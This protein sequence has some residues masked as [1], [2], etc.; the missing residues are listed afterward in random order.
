VISSAVA[1]PLRPGHPQTVYYLLGGG[2]SFLLALA[3]TLNQ[4]YYL[5]VVGL[6]PFQ[7]VLDGT[8]LEATCFL[9]EIP[10]GI[11]PDLYSRRL[12]VIVGVALLGAGML[13]QGLARRWPRR[14]WP[15]WCGAPARPSSLVPTR[16]GWPSRSART[17]SVRCS[18]ERP[19]SAWR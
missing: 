8:V 17:P 1:A 6:S 14:W 4:V 12:S 15:R 13:F 3:F 7:M 10:T 19:S 5:T 11:V 16:P 2:V 9:G 18:P